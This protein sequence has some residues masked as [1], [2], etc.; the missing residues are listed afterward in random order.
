MNDALTGVVEAQTKKVSSN[1]KARH[2]K[3]S[4]PRTWL[5]WT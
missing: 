3:S 1:S 5:Q 2:Y 4:T